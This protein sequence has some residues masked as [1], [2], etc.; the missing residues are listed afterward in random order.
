MGTQDELM[1]TGPKKSICVVGARH[2]P[3]ASHLWRRALQS[4]GQA[5]SAVSL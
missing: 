4:M 3:R 5:G 1:W 2:Y